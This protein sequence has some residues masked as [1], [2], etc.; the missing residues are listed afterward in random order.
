MSSTTSMPQDISQPR[1]QSFLQNLLRS[2]W[3]FVGLQ[4]LDLA[5]TLAAFHYGAFEVNPLVAGLTQHLGR[6]RGVA[7][8]KVLAVCVA[9]GVKRLVWIVNLFYAGI[10]VWNALVVIALSA[11][12]H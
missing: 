5:T 12:S 1:S 7:A 4:A 9:L 10:V 2:R 3:T 8:S 11:R 6:F